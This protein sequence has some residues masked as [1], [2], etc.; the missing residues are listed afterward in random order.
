MNFEKTIFFMKTH[1]CV[2]KRLESHIWTGKRVNFENS[3]FFM[4]THDLRHDDL[5]LT[6]ELGKKS[7]LKIRYFFIKIFLCKWKRL[8]SHIWIGNNKETWISHLNLVKCELW[9]SKYLWKSLKIQ[10]FFM[11]T[12]KCA[13]NRLESIIWTR[14]SVIFLKSSIFFHENLWNLTKR[15]DSLIW[16]GNNV[17]VENSISFNENS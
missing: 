13:W 6:T 2:Y 4:K 17:I 8:E 12:H 16:T 9:K 10:Y 1:E 3:I 14:N 5:N 11:N 7:T 15:I